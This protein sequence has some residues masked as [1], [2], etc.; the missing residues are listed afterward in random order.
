MSYG[1]GIWSNLS[2]AAARSPLLTPSFPYRGATHWFAASPAPLYIKQ[3]R[4]GQVAIHLSHSFSGP[5]INRWRCR[6]KRKQPV[7]AS[8]Q[9]AVPRAGLPRPRHSRHPSPRPSANQR[10]T[11]SVRAG[12]DPSDS[13]PLGEKESLPTAAVRHRGVCARAVCAADTLSA[14]AATRGP[15]SAPRQ[16]QPGLRCVDRGAVASQAS[17]PPT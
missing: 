1:E 15:P 17:K 16:S 3:G 8:T 5:Y 10:R 11:G 13:S 4:T 6:A 12:A 9:C 7:L 14:L 2:L